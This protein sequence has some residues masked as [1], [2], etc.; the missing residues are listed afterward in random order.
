MGSVMPDAVSHKIQIAICSHKRPQMLADT[1]RSL[2]EMT[3][4]H[5]ASVSLTIVDNDHA[6]SAENTVRSFSENTPLSVTYHCEP[7]R[8]IPVARNHA[9]RAAIRDGI[10]YLIFIDDDEWVEKNWLQELYQFANKQKQPAIVIGHVISDL[11]PSAPKHLQPFFQRTTFPAGAD[12]NH[13][14]SNNMLLP[15]ELITAL[16]L[17]FDETHPLSGGDDAQFFE[18]ARKNGI[19]ILSCPQAVVH[20]TIPE[21]RAT[22]RWLSARKFRVGINGALRKRD[23]GQPLVAFF[24]S[25]ALVGLASLLGAGAAA[26]FFR[27]NIR[28][29]RWLRACKSA[30]SCCGVLQVPFNHYRTTDGN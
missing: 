8:G 3:L 4:P 19:K 26:L 15:I 11:P 1:L 6:C 13:G 9:L 30:G 5:N 28:I 18:T 12:R 22:L 7:S 27:R 24:I 23:A 20:E 10:D 21:N 29:R 2:R 17:Q 16:G 14:A 25:R